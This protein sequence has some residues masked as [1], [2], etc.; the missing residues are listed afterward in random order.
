[1]T[2][3]SNSVT[4]AHATAETT[5]DLHGRFALVIRQIAEDHH[6]LRSPFFKRLRNLPA[7]VACDPELLGKIHLV[8]QSAMHATRAAVYYLP[9]LDSPAMRKRKLRIFIDDDGLPGG[10]THHYQLSRAFRNMG[11]KLV[12]DDEDFSGG[13]ELCR[14]LDPETS[15]FVQWAATLY[16]RSLGPWCV[17]ELMS[18]SWMR[19]L[20]DSLSAHFPAVT[21]EPYFADCFSQGV[22]ERHADESLEVTATV[23]QARPELYSETVL[24]AK[25]MAESLDGVWRRLD[26]IVKM[27]EQKNRAPKDVRL[28]GTEP[29][30]QPR[31]RAF[32]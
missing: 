21:N 26:T 19:A 17:V 16:A 29:P 2:H 5:L 3:V 4:P 12:L 31:A 10:D 7:A 8:Y 11:A 25:L 1:M 13:T 30:R 9:H 23:L 22:E 14:H 32:V 18:D 15:R 24:D 27:A 28:N 6:P 20:A